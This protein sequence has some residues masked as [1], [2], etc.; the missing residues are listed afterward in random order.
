MKPFL[1]ISLV[2][3]GLAMLTSTQAALPLPFFNSIRVRMIKD[4][5]ANI[6]NILYG[7]VPKFL[8][9]SFWKNVDPDIYLT[10]SLNVISVHTLTY[11]KLAMM[12]SRKGYPIEVHTII[13]EDGY[14]LTVMP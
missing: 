1:A 8:K 3:L 14:M 4:T 2:I 5:L 6:G 12:I 7:F 13:T 11:Q 9:P 10:P